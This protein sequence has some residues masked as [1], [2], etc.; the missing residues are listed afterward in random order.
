MFIYQK[1]LYNSIKSC[2]QTIYN[3]DFDFFL[4]KNFGIKLVFDT[5]TYYYHCG[6]RHHRYTVAA[7]IYLSALRVWQTIILSWQKKTIY[8]FLY[9]ER[10]K[11]IF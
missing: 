10:E 7:T 2:P 3:N 4:K 8:N 1:K 11:N 9:L 6:G 5:I